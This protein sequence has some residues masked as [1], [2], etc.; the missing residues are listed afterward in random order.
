M[1]TR[2]EFKASQ[3]HETLKAESG[4]SESQNKDVRTDPPRLPRA[5]IKGVHHHA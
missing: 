4:E 1:A 3:I 2:G 5:G